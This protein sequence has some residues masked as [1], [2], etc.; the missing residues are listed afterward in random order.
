MTVADL[1]EVLQQC[2]YPN[3]P[4]KVRTLAVDEHED[5]FMRRLEVE[6]VGFEAGAVMLEI[7]NVG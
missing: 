6:D 7:E 2:P 1:I 3:A 4:V 5:V